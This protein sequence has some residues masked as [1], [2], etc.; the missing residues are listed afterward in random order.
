VHPT[1]YPRTY[2]FASDHAGVDMKNQCVAWFESRGSVLDLGTYDAALSVNYPEYALRLVDYLAMHP[3][4]EGVLVC[5][6]GIGMSIAAN[7]FPH[8]RAAL[9]RSVE[10]AVWARKHNHANVLVLGARAEATCTDLIPILTAWVQTPF[11]G[12]RHDLRVD[13]LSSLLR[14]S[15][16]QTSPS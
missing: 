15:S 5:G 16:M 3:D 6:S 10:D 13:Q 2:V 9:C 7:R 4:S 12:G 11:E 14:P 8:I 1:T